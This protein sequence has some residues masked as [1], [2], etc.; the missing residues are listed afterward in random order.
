VVNCVSAGGGGT[1]AYR[2]SYIAG[3]ESI[4]AWTHARG[5]VG[6]FVYTSSTSV[7]PQS[8]G[9][10]VDETAPTLGA[11]DRGQLL[12]DS[13]SRLQSGTGTCA[14][15]FVLRLA[16]IYGPGRHHLL[17]QVRAGEVSG[18]SEHHLNLIHRDDVAS[19]VAACFAARPAI[20]SQIFNVADDGPTVK[21]EIVGWLA[22]E[23]GLPVPR[24]TGEPGAGRRAVTPDRI[25]VNAKLKEK[26]GWR[27]RYS[28][29]REGYASLL[30]R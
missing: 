9:A 26:L 25:I 17:E 23:L 20:E 13:E 27:P 1:E 4:V 19:A 8:G 16:G 30:S 10:R 24:F 3:M 14:R 2:H 21:S 7:Y 18:M 5:P 12:L 15:W 6:T 28:T 29:F 22:K 11:S